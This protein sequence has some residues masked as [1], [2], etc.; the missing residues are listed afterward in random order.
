MDH[1]PVMRENVLFYL[2]DFREGTIIDGTVG[3]GGHTEALLEATPAA[4]HVLGIDRDLEALTA[5]RRRLRDFGDRFTAV[6]AS[7]ADIDTWKSLISRKPVIGFLMDLGLSSVQMDTPGRGFSFNDPVALDMR[8]DTR[9]AGETAADIVNEWSEE[10]LADIIY[11]FGEDKA[12]RR[13]ARAIVRRRATAPFQSAADLAAVVA[14]A[15]PGKPQKIHPATRTFQA[16][17]IAV[18]GELDHLEKG[19]KAGEM[20][21]DPGGHLVIIAFHSLEDRMVKRFFIRRSGV[22]TCPPGLPV[23]VCRPRAAFRILTRHPETPKDAE[24]SNNP[25]ARSARLRCAERLPDEG[26]VL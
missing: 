23:C 16:L 2:R 4:I 3:L 12:S 14:G 20:V 13:I 6:Q 11:R 18:N 10:M 15:V 1:L 22:C 5:S 26:G 17:R 21:L 8:F 25:R 7:Y 9:G 24:V 19:L